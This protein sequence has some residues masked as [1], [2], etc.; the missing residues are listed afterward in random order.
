MGLARSLQ[1]WIPQGLDASG[2]YTDLPPCPTGSAAS[3]APSPL[4][5]VGQWEE[6]DELPTDLT[7]SWF[8]LRPL[9]ADPTDPD[10]DAAGATIYYGLVPTGSSDVDPSG[11]SRFDDDS[12]YEIRCF[13]RRHKTACT[14][15]GPQCHCP[16][17]WSDPTESYQIA[18][19][20]DLQGTANRP[21]TVQMPDL[22]QLKSAAL[23]GPPTGGLNLKAPQSL[24]VSASGFPP[25]GSTGG[26][27]ICSFAI[28]LLTIVATF[29][30]K[31]FL[32]IVV[33]AFQL[34]FLLALKFCIPPEVS[35]Q[36]G[37]AAALAV[38]PPTAAGWASLSASLQADIET[39]VSS[40]FGGSPD[41]DS[42]VTALQSNPGDLVALAKMLFATP[43]PPW[44]P[45]DLVFAPHVD[46]WTVQP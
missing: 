16:V 45:P 31:L 18:P 19:H 30:F 36:A 20:F 5:G 14:R 6:V 38:T 39:D 32:P 9:I 24:N 7:E 35:V 28:P 17:V 34:W 29:V 33:L 8:P 25:G 40:L 27:E 15:T 3:P 2:D 23:S 13:V 26:A 22:N 41:G 44:R 37:L 4:A 21:V 42:A 11:T 12:I 1:G 43:V 46:R 10:S